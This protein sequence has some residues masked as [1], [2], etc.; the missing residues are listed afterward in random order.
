MRF[1]RRLTGFKVSNKMDNRLGHSRFCPVRT[2]RLND[3]GAFFT[4]CEFL[5]C[6]RLIAMGT[7]QGEVWLYNLHTGAVS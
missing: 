1:I 4:C 2:F 7:Y 3:E 6:G 5:P